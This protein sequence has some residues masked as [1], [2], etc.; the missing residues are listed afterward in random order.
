[1]KM[2]ITDDTITVELDMDI[3]QK[4]N[5][6]YNFK[7]KQI[8]KDTLHIDSGTDEWILELEQKKH[9][10]HKNLILMHKNHRRNLNHHHEQ[11]R[12]F[13]YNWVFGAINNHEQRWFRKLNH[14]NRIIDSIN[15]VFS[16]N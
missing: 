10:Q 12:Y 5:S 13:D 4:I 2:T 9:P 16:S 3:I 14:M 7:I 15:R 8:T 11:R 6:R 1:M